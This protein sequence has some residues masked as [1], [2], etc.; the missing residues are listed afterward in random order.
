MPVNGT[1]GEYDASAASWS[2]ALTCWLVRMADFDAL[3]GNGVGGQ[4]VVPLGLEAP[5]RGVPALKRRAIV[6]L[7]RWD[8][9]DG[10][11]NVAS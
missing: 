2:R 1:H 4:S 3:P 6:M 5:G 7:S 11:G 10:N 9:G 8:G